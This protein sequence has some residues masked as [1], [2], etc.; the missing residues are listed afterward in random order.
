MVGAFGL[1]L[2]SLS[3]GRRAGTSCVPGSTA[4]M[5][6]ARSPVDGESITRR[7]GVGTVTALVSPVAHCKLSPASGLSRRAGQ[8]L[9]LEC[10]RWRSGYLA[11]RGGS[12]NACP[13]GVRTS[14]GRVPATGG[15]G[16]H[17]P[18]QGRAP[19][20]RIHGIAP[21]SCRPTTSGP[22]GGGG[23]ANP[24]DRTVTPIIGRG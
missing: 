10:R 17:R 6:A 20:Q 19:G 22:G 15:P 21:F 11:L 7:S 18:D 8:G 23:E 2:A 13:E 14:H 1:R 4:V 16:G 9:E 5:A 12:R 24:R 3:E